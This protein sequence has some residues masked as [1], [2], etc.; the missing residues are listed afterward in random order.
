M[1]IVSGFNVYPTDVEQVLYRHEKIEKV[2]VAGVPDS[3]TGEAVKAYI[4]LKQ[5]ENA[6]AEEIIAWCK[7]EKTGLTGYRVPKLI[8]F[9]D[10]LPETMI[11]KVLRRVLVEEEKQKAAQ[12]G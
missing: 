3:K 7:D 11:G 9:R 1:I 5:G 2:A 10:A 8:E 6:T 4:V 12:A